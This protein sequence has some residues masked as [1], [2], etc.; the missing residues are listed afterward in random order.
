MDGVFVCLA[1][2]PQRRLHRVFI[3]R[4]SN[5]SQLGHPPQNVVLPLPGA[6]Q[7][8]YRVVHGGRLGQPGEHGGLGEAQLLERFAEVDLRRGG[9]AVSAL[10]QIN[11]VHVEL[12]DLVLG[13]AVLDLEGEEHFVQLARGCF[14]RGE[15]KVAR[16]LHR[17]G[18]GALAA[19][20][21]DE[22]GVGRAQHSYIIDA[23]VLIEALVLGGKDGVL[24]RVGDF[25]DR[26]HRAT[27]LAELADQHAL[28]GV[29]PQGN[30]G[31]VLGQRLQRRQVR[32]GERDHQGDS[33]YGGH[34]Q[35]R[36]QGQR[37]G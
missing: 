34:C 8:R 29:N 17:D 30:L 11:L 32:V 6:L 33:Q 12:E 2:R 18:A 19:A 22:V 16:H 37:K 13:Q 5:M 25:L 23:R 24:E 27:L 4:C 28:R 1:P 3:L 36:Q 10:P 20:A 7:I 14:L 21:G 15:E 26:H 35:P 31:L 9:K